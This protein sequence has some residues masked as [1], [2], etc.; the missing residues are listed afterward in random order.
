M[1]EKVEGYVTREGRFIDV[2]IMECSK[3]G[4]WGSNHLAW[5]HERNIKEE[6]LLKEKK[7]VKITGV[8]DSGY[9]FLGLHLSS[10]QVRTMRRLGIEPEEEDLI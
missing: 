4:Y 8:L 6:D 5:C 3:K 7:W 10:E 9:L 1:N 2:R